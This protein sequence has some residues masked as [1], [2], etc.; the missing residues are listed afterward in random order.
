MF[1]TLVFVTFVAIN[2]QLLFLSLPV[3]IIMNMII[4]YEYSRSSTCIYC[5]S[6][7]YVVSNR[8]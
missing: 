4:M 3:V 2:N 6:T 1:L 5:V 8:Q 7:F